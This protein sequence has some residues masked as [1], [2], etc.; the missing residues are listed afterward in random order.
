MKWIRL[1]LCICPTRE[2]TVPSETPSVRAMVENGMRPSSCSRATISRL[3][4]S[5]WGIEDGATASSCRSAIPIWRK[6]MIGAGS[7]SAR[8]RSRGSRLFPFAREGG[9]EALMP[10]PNR[11]NGFQ[12]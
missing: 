4:P 6:P 1:A 8:A 3:S 11:I 2:R 10:S 12:P 7:A 9:F 5:I